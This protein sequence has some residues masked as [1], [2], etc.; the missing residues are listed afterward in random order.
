MYFLGY[1]GALISSLTSPAT[2]PPINTYEQL[3][4]SDHYQ[5]AFA[6]KGNLF[7]H[8]M[9]TSH[10]DILQRLYKKTPSNNRLYVRAEDFLYNPRAVRIGDRQATLIRAQ[11]DWALPSGKC[12]CR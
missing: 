6:K 11:S 7:E 10:D 2:Y 9:N 4:H 1:S 8:L 3:L 12:H 5:L